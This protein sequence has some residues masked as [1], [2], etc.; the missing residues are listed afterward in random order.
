MKK[1]IFIGFLVTILALAFSLPAY[2]A[3][4]DGKIPLVDEQANFGN[5]LD[6]AAFYKDEQFS[7]DMVWVDGKN[8]K[9]VEL[10]GSIREQLRFDASKLADAKGLTLSMWVYWKGARADETD[11]G[12]LLFGLSSTTGHFKLEVKDVTRTSGLNFAGGWYNED[13]YCETDYA[14]PQDKWCMVTATLD[15]TNM[16]LYLDGKQIAKQPQTVVPADLGIDL[17]RIG[18]SWWGPPT[19]NGIVDDAAFWTR[20]LSASE[21]TAMYRATGGTASSG[22]ASTGDA[23]N[24]F[25]A[26]GVLLISTAAVFVLKSKKVKE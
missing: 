14:L 4:G 2:A 1:R 7:T 5:D 25:L 22:S 20:A 23:F 11:G 19:L 18:S 24:M 26:A 13:V 6:F 15:G 3:W 16:V 21:V 9:G 8:G 12:V 10:G 17:F